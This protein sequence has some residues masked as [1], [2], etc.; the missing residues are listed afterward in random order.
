MAR[1]AVTMLRTRQAAAAGLLITNHEAAGLAACFLSAAILHVSELVNPH[2]VHEQTVILNTC[3][4][5]TEFSLSP[6][7]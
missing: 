2:Q 3:S 7:C 4:F 6:P 1:P 5:V